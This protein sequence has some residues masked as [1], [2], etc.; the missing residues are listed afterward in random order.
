MKFGSSASSSDRSGVS[1]PS[2]RAA[3]WSMVVPARMSAPSVRFGRTP[4]SQ[5]ALARAWVPLPTSSGLASALARPPRTIVRSRYGSSGRRIG[6]ISNPAPAPAGRKFSIWT[7]FGTYRKPIRMR[8]CAGVCDNAESA[9]HHRIEQRQG[10]RCAHAPQERAPRQRP[11]RDD[12][13]ASARGDAVRRIRNASWWMI[14]STSAE[15]RNSSAAA[16]RTIRRTPGMSYG[17]SPR[18]SA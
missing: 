17:S 3:N 5:T 7:P 2:D 9:G 15:S 6:V 1:L 16:A 4:F 8:G 18:P 10:E 11:L 12:H 13:S 14:P